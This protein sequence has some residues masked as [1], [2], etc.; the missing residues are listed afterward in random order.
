M[1]VSQQPFAGSFQD[2]HSGVAFG[3]AARRMGMEAVLAIPV[4]NHQN[5]L[6]EAGTWP[7]QVENSE[8][9]FQLVS[10]QDVQAQAHETQD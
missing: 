1:C 6:L 9:A 3:S 10:R 7:H 4:A 5:V 2:V 8:P